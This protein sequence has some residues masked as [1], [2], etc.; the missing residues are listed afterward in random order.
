MTDDW[1][2]ARTPFDQLDTDWATIC[3]RTR[4]SNVLGRWAGQEPDLAQLRRLEEVIPSRWVEREARCAA[5]AR[6]HIGG[7]DLAGRVLLQL[8]IPGM[9]VVA[10]KWRPQYSGVSEACWDVITRTSIYIAQLRE[11]TIRCS[12]AGYA[13]V[14]VRRDLALEARRRARDDNELGAVWGDH[15]DDDTSLALPSAEETAITGS[16]LRAD[17]EEA[18]R[19]LALP[20]DAVETIWLILCGY[21]VPEAAQATDQPVSTSY[22]YRDRVY[23]HL[24]G[25]LA[26]DDT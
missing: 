23:Q 10:A 22:R 16:L 21:S 1:V 3:R 26:G 11:R 4:R 8:L 17:L 13:L 25:Q 12:P 18:A 2:F 5:V 9:T 15:H 14:S 6:L 7:D 20:P 19:N 24:Y